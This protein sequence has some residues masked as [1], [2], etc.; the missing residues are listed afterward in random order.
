[1][2][3]NNEIP[4]NPNSSLTVLYTIFSEWN[5]NTIKKGRLTYDEVSNE[6]HGYPWSGDAVKVFTSKMSNDSQLKCVVLAVARYH[7][8]ESVEL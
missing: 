2:V 3:E 4:V 1:M 7:H 5:V 8:F 6:I